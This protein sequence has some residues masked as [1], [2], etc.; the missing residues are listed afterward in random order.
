MSSY[1]N[2][3]GRALIP[4][5]FLLGFITSTEAQQQTWVGYVTDTHCGTNCQVTKNM[6]PDLKC[7]R[8][9]VKQGS[10]YG[11]WSG[12]KVYALEPQAKAMGF[13]AKNVKVIGTMTGDTIQATEIR[14][15][16]PPNPNISSSSRCACV[17]QLTIKNYL[18]N[19]PVSVKHRNDLGPSFSD[20]LFKRGSG[21]LEPRVMRAVVPCKHLGLSGSDDPVSG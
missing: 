6:T 2:S 17:R 8:R 12:E 4:L 14:T 9:C 19:S 15:N 10:K 20:S 3:W 1:I 16:C 11:L 13:A 7:I 5:L 18:V 21:A